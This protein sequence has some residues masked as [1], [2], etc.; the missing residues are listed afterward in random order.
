MDGD[1]ESRVA[2]QSD[3]Q[4]LRSSNRI[5][6]RGFAVILL[7]VSVFL[8]VSLIQTQQISQQMQQ[9]IEENAIKGQHAQIMRNAARERVTMLLMALYEQDPFVKDEL[10]MEFD[11]L[12]GAFILAGRGLGEMDLSLLERQA[13][14]KATLYA[15]QGTVALK[16]ARD[17]IMD[18]EITQPLQH[19]VVNLISEEI[20]PARLGVSMAINEIQLVQQEAGDQALQMLAQSRVQSNFLLLLL[21]VAVLV[22]SFW[23]TRSVVRQNGRIGETLSRAKEEVEQAMVAKNDFLSTMSHEIRTPMNGIV[24]LCYL[25]QKCELNRSVKT[26]VD[27]IEGAANALLDIINDILDLS[28][29]EAAQLELEEIDFDLGQVLEQVS[30]ITLFKGR[31]KGLTMSLERDPDL[32]F[33]KGDPTRLRQ[34]LINLINNAIKFTEEGG[35]AVVASVKEQSEDVIT[36]QFRV[37]DSGIGICEAQQLRLFKPFSQA[38]RS[39]TRKYGGTGLGLSISKQ[40]VEGM[41]GE[42]GVESELGVGSTF[43]F[44]LPFKRGYELPPSQQ[45]YSEDQSSNLPLEGMQVLVVEDNRTNQI[46]TEQLLLDEGAEVTIAE[47]GVVALEVAQQQRY[48]LIL[49]DIQMPRMD[50]YEAT[51]QLRKRYSE[52]ELPIIALTANAMKGDREQALAVGMNDY[53]TKPIDVEALFGALKLWRGAESQQTVDESVAE[54]VAE[55]PERLPGLEV[56]E[57][58]E[59]VSGNWELYL[60]V[61]EM[62][63]EDCR[64]FSSQRSQSLESGEQDQLKVLLH[65]LKGSATNVSANALAE[66]ALILERSLKQGQVISVE[67]WTSFDVVMQQTLTSVDSLLP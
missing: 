13:L 59:R 36:L 63:A 15:Q 4:L 51:R 66:Q 62:F 18:H 67:Q 52:Q 49:M 35:V 11:R 25:L 1:L 43:F 30:S 12:A 8:V 39:T 55:W 20:I 57:G 53:L 45:G 19:R 47:D 33:L 50:G 46:V 31:E 54:E 29:I 9:V 3:E 14:E 60:K 61:V 58:V 28:K 5:I 17:L 38:E 34:G 7:F 23:I 6:Y 2:A 37:E 22:S 64:D 65:T 21:G 41:G 26:Y 10:F 16:N 24:G 48:D 40:L 44:T 56:A 32:S 27:K 42:I